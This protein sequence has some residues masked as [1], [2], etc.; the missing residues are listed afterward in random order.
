[1]GMERTVWV[2]RWCIPATDQWGLS[3]VVQCCRWKTGKNSVAVVQ[4]VWGRDEWCR[5]RGRVVDE[6]SVDDA[7]GKICSCNTRDIFAHWQLRVDPPA[8]ITN[9]GH[10]LDDAVVHRD[11]PCRWKCVAELNHR[12]SVLSPINYNIQHI[13]QQTIH[14]TARIYVIQSDPIKHYD[15]SYYLGTYRQIDAAFVVKQLEQ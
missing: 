14:W 13:D 3:A 6:Q 11:G 9:D 4:V 2:D 5:H 7:V 1:M 8:Q 10:W 15:S 12:S